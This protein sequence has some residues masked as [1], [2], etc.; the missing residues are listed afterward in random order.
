MHTDQYLHFE[1]HRPTHVKRGV[2][3]CLHDRAMEIISMQSKFQKEVDHLIRVLKQ[4]G[5]PAN[6][7]RNASALPTEETVDTCNCDEEQ[8]EERGLLVVTPYV[9]GMREDIRHVCREFNIKAVTL[10]SILTKVKDTLLLSKQS[11]VV[12]HIPCSCS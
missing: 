3:R 1:S 5:Y 7:I 9:A 2:G 12:Y 6:F 8:E 11:N 10:R 4:N